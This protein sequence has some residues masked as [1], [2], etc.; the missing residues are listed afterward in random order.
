MARSVF[1]GLK[2]DLQW[3][4]AFPRKLFFC[5]CH[6]IIISI[7]LTASF[8][9]SCSKEDNS[10]PEDKGII[11]G[12]YEGMLVDDTVK[13]IDA[14]Y[15]DGDMIYIDFDR[16][17]TADLRLVVA[18]WGSPGLGIHYM[19]EVEPLSPNTSLFGIF[20]MDT[21]FLDRDIGHY[22]DGYNNYQVTTEYYSCMRKSPADIVS[23]YGTDFHVVNLNFNENLKL[24]DTFSPDTVSFI[25]HSQ[26]PQYTSVQNDTVFIH[27]SFYESDCYTV[28]YGEEIY[29]GVKF[30]DCNERLGWIK[31]ILQSE[32]KMTLLEYAIQKKSN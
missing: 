23:S 3:L 25:Y 26:S 27:Q 20:T 9:V 12:N 15:N 13:V 28:P 30:R 6:F 7:I 8:V 21:V 2:T 17:D 16:N 14:G 32:T 4:F 29:L 5:K 24:T 1:F 10:I 31:I 19:S 18:C 11:I 22:S